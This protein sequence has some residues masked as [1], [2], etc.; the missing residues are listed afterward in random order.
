M[1]SRPALPVAALLLLVA[2][3]ARSQPSDGDPAVLFSPA[4]MMGGFEE[5]F[6]RNVVPTFTR[7]DVIAA[8]SVLRTQESAVGA[9]RPEAGG[10]EGAV[11][12][13][14]VALLEPIAE[15]VPPRSP[16][17][18]PTAFAPDAIAPLRKH[19]ATPTETASASPPSPGP[20]WTRRDLPPA[21]TPTPAATLAKPVQKARGRLGAVG[22]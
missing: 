1:L 7:P 15:E 8:V 11:G 20:L 3:P 22:R 5:R 6:E 9:P 17:Q 21:A 14:S 18:P 4:P 10:L 13:P 2:A 16:P 19:T 12:V